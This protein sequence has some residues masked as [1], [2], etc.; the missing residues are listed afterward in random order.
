M[1]AKDGGRIEP[2]APGGPTSQPPLG[3]ENPAEYWMEA[4][5]KPQMR[6]LRGLLGEIAAVSALGSQGRNQR[7]G[8]RIGPADPGE[9]L[10]ASSIRDAPSPAPCPARCSGSRVQL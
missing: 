2:E 4:P 1:A 9:I 6:A 7:R 8:E 5:H 10:T 3:P